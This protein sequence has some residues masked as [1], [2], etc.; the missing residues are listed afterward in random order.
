M[1]KKKPIQAKLNR[2]EFLQVAGKKLRLAGTSGHSS[3][4]QFESVLGRVDPMPGTRPTVTSRKS[5][6]P[7]LN[8]VLTRI[9][10]QQDTKRRKS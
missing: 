3:R 8:V 9:E 7:Q 2:P 4:P 1:P 5:T 10:A 6:R